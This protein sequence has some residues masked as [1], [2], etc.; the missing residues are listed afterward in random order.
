VLAY[1]YFP[2]S[3]DVVID[4]NDSYIATTSNNSIRLRN[5][6][7]H[8]IGHSLGLPHVCPV[9]QTKLM[10]PF[11]NLSFRGS[12][13]DDVYSQQRRYG[14]PLEAHGT[15]RNNDSAAN[16]TTLALVTGSTSAWQW[17]SIDD[18]SDT[19]FFSLSAT[20][21]QLVTVRVIPSDPILPADPDTD[22]YLEGAQNSDGSCSAGSAFDPTTQQDLVLDLLAADGSTVVASAPARAAGATEEISAV[23]P[24]ADGNYYIRV[25]G[26]TTDRAQL[27][28]LEVLVVDAPPAPDIAITSTRI[29][30]ESNSGA[31][32]VPD[33]DETI[34]LGITL[35]KNGNLPATDLDVTVTA[36]GATF[37]SGSASYGS[38][39]PGESGERMFT[40]ALAGLPGDVVEMQLA[41]TADEYT[42]ILP[43][44]LTLGTVLT[45]TPLHEDFDDSPSLPAT[46]TQE[47]SGAGSPW[48]ISSSRSGSAPNSAFSASITPN[49]EALLL[50]PA[51]LIGQGGG[52]LEF[53]HRYLL[54]TSRDGGVLEAS[55][56]GGAWF[57][58]MNSAATVQAG[59]YNGAINSGSSSAIRGRQ[60]WTGSA[61]AFVT[62]RV[63]LPAA[64]TGESII[65]RWRLVHNSATVV[66]G[67]HVDDVSFS[68]TLPGSDPFRPV[69]SLTATGAVLSEAEAE[70][71]LLLTLSTPLP[72]VQAVSVPLAVAGTAAAADVSGPLTLTLPA[73]QTSVSVEL[74]AVPDGMAEGTESLLLSIPGEEPGYAPSEP[75]AVSVL[76]EDEPLL[77]ATVALGGLDAL[78]DGT[79]KAA[80]ATTEPAGLMVALTYDG[81]TEAPR[82]SGSYEVIATVVTP[83]YTGTAE[84]TL[85][86]R[87]AYSAWIAA[88]AGPA[89]DVATTADIDGDGWDNLG[90]YAF[91]TDP[92]EPSSFP[93]L[94][95]VLADGSL[96]LVL[97]D[98]PPGVDFE[99]QTSTDLMTWTEEGVSASP[100]GVEVP[101]DG[102]RRYLRIAY[103]LSE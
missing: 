57:D 67:W 71:S 83:G 9:N 11:I 26:G 80:T 34:R 6:L 31:N 63:A 44:P 85:V 56:N 92:A 96:H 87:S 59:D 37:F 38:L 27:Y 61:A 33:P 3:G 66:T 52:V 64:W 5:I 60:A 95:P 30:A 25:R 16:A 28:R 19:D 29:D 76:I 13:F 101:R 82:K 36:A 99:A 43:L 10:E 73:G 100:A 93:R 65:F 81:N 55:R 94:E 62:T 69:L 2:D 47:T 77:P 32:G 72:L 41:V 79:P 48:T 75:S 18:N 17:L 78:F 102:D 1:A 24:P 103:T 40:F 84:G 89:D 8:E 54:E 98:P 91:G 45:S 46:W 97:P 68:S 20:R 58:L 15:L 88:I 22:T 50:A 70:A 14:D 23:R 42:T 86:I 7:E 21:S 90:E 74:T 51:I 4:T 53:Q 35:A 39:A 49:G 12:Q